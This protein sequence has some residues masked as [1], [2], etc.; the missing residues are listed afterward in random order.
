MPAT[1]SR[2]AIESA[3]LGMLE[4]RKA[5]EE[6]ETRKGVASSAEHARLTRAFARATE[7]YLRLSAAN[8]D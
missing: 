7:S 8:G 5:L 3:R 2:Q 6:H 4:A 1:A